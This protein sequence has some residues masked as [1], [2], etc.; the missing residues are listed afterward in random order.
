MRFL[1]LFSSGLWSRD[2]FLAR[3]PLQPTGELSR[4]GEVYQCRCAV[5]T[6]M[7]YDDRI[8]NLCY[9]SERVG[10]MCLSQERIQT[11]PTINPHLLSMCRFQ[12]PSTH[13]LCTVPGQ[14]TSWV[15]SICKEHLRSGFSAF[16]IMSIHISIYVNSF[17]IHIYTVYTV[18]TTCL[19]TLGIIEVSR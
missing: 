9:L 15:T 5:Y 16:H 4:I 12:H 3:S 1:S 8:V 13:P 6:S 7:L 14:N 18:Y 2:M 17:Q 10:D 11:Q 19:P